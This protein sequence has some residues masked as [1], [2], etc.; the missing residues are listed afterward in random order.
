[1]E[2]TGNTFEDT[3]VPVRGNAILRRSSDDDL[4]GKFPPSDDAEYLD[5]D[6]D[7]SLIVRCPFCSVNFSGARDNVEEELFDHI[8]ARHSDEALDY[9]VNNMY[10]PDDLKMEIFDR[11]GL[12][13]ISWL[14]DRDGEFD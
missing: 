5:D 8:W 11:L 7:I 9:I 10:I 1:M 2:N 14:V 12:E 13:Y 3:V 6:E 4:D